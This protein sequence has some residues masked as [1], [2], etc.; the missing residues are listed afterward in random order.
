MRL[1]EAPTGLTIE[2]A[3]RGNKQAPNTHSAASLYLAS[4]GW[5]SPLALAVIGMLSE[6]PRDNY[7]QAPRGNV[8]ERALVYP[9][10][11]LNHVHF[12]RLN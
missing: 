9:A 5:T 3:S 2:A 1:G 8:H 10:L 4:T 7:L 6:A 12:L 11:Q